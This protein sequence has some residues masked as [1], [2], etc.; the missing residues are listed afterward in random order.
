MGA[1]DPGVMSRAPNEAGI[2]RWDVVVPP[3]AKGNDAFTL[4]YTFRLEY[5]RQM[6]ITEAR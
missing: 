5:D 2:L 6:G 3:G 4:E 1:L